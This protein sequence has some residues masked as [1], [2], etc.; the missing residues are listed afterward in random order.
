MQ[1]RRLLPILTGSRSAFLEQCRASYPNLATAFSFGDSKEPLTRKAAN[2]LPTL[3]AQLCNHR[4]ELPEEVI[5][6]Y[7]ACNNG[8]QVASYI[9]DEISKDPKF[10]NFPSN[11]QE[12]IQKTLI[13]RANGM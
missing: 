11:L 5:K 3:G 9:R 4:A 7:K 6:L 8:T 12:E 1:P 2:F 10:K 13:S